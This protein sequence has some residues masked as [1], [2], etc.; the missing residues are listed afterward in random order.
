MNPW[1][2]SRNPFG[3][4]FYQNDPQYRKPLKASTNHGVSAICIN[5]IWFETFPFHIGKLRRIKRGV[6]EQTLTENNPDI[7][8]A[9]TSEFTSGYLTKLQK[10]KKVLQVILLISI[11]RM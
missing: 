11:N 2:T 1:L 5:V 4:L 6:E 7:P 9:V 8:V 3:F 10:A